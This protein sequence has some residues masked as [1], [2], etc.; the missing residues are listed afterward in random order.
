MSLFRDIFDP[1]TEEGKDQGNAV[2]AA[3]DDYQNFCV[4]EYIWVG[5]RGNVR[6]KTRTLTRKPESPDDCSIWMF[7]G[8]STAQA[9]EAESDVY[10]V[11]RRVFE[12]PI[13]GPPHVLIVCEAVVHSMEPAAGNYRADATEAMV[14]YAGTDAWFS[15]EQ[16]Y[17]LNKAGKMGHD[18]AGTKFACQPYAFDDDGNC[19]EEE[20]FYCGVGGLNVLEGHRFLVDD[21]YA[22]CMASGIKIQHAN[23]GVAAGSG[24]FQIG[25]CRGINIGDHL[26]AARWL[27]K[28]ASE[29]YADMFY[30]S[31]NPQ[32]VQG[33]HGNGVNIS[34]SS[35][36][37][38]G[39]GG[40]QVVEK[41]CRALGRKHKETLQCYGT[42][43]D[44]RLTGK[45]QT[46]PAD[47]FRF[48]VADMTASVRI[49]RNVAVT[50]RGELCD[51]RP[52]G[53]CDPYRAAGIIMSVC[54]D[55]LGNR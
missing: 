16:E 34:F 9:T 27:L 46:C 26:V 53:D 37:T 47:E 36:Q 38:R 8:S 55:V 7:D 5:G 19:G 18:E 6:S 40:L 42:G 32:P 24:C 31:F 3:A 52:A 35:R 28:V 10:L 20:N 39:E 17:S 33:R 15:M 11:P 1:E 51:R 29:K 13:R 30:I 2:L 49:P 44:E 4:A 23:L 48:G 14:K 54:G 50:G 41:C 25:P 22:L 45:N 43:H 12:D 21:H